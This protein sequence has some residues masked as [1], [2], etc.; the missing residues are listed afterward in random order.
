[1][2]IDYERLR[3]LFGTASYDRLREIHRQWVNEYVDKTEKNREEEWTRSIAVGSQPFVES[4]I[5]TGAG[6]TL[7]TI[8]SPLPLREG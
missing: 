7:S 4:D 8:S 1:V 2:L 6:S 5:K 3:D